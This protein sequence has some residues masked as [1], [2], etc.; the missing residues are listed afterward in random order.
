MLDGRAGGASMSIMTE[1]DTVTTPPVGTDDDPAQ[2]HAR[3]TYDAG[4]RCFAKAGAME[5]KGLPIPRM[6]SLL[7]ANPCWWDLY[8]RRVPRFR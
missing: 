6:H 1:M 4:G 3:R 8:L 7:C 5:R 2:I